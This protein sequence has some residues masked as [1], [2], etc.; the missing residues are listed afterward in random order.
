MY[1]TIGRLARYWRTLRDLSSDGVP[2]IYSHLLAE[3]AQVTAAQVRRDLM[4]VGYTGTPA[5][6]YDVKKLREH[7]EAYLFP[8]NGE[9]QK[10]AIAG[11]GNFGRALLK[12]FDG[13]RPSLEIVASFE[14]NPEK[15][16]RV[17]DGCPCYSIEKA[18]DIIREMGITVGIIAVPDRE[19]QSIADIFV[20]SGIRGI[21]NFARK[22]LKTP[23]DIYVEEI[24]L[25]MSMDRVAYFAR[26]PLKAKG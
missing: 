4:A 13:R 7:V 26:Q 25:A 24:D 11:L 20:E 19:S 15:F 14:I 3:K 2:Y 8:A 1:R 12:F 18:A 21:M 10:A 9:R 23:E 17:I 6:G 16:N 5:H 22:P